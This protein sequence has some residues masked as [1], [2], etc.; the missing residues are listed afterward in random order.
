D[1]APIVGVTNNQRSCT[2]YTF[3]ARVQ[4]QRVRSR[5]LCRPF[6]AVTDAYEPRIDVVDGQAI[7]AERGRRQRTRTRRIAP[8]SLAIRRRQLMPELT[9]DSARSSA[10]SRGK[11]HAR[12]SSPGGTARRRLSIEVK[13]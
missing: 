2:E 12:S 7:I 4:Q 9:T 13:S 3:R 11:L 1:C 5:T 8:D 6:I 10:C